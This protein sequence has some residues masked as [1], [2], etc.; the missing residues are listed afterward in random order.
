[1]SLYLKKTGYMSN[2]YNKLLMDFKSPYNNTQY[3]LYKRGYNSF[4]NKIT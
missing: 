4:P 1:M 3:R 2:Y